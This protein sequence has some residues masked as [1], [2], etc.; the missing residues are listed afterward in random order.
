MAGKYKTKQQEAII[1]C[2][3]MQKDEYVTVNQIEK[4]LKEKECEVGLTTIYRH[5]EKLIED[6]VV[7]RLTVEGQSGACYKFI[8]ADDNESGFYI[9]CEKCGEVAQ[10]KCHH[11]DELYEHVEDDHDFVINTKKT[12]FYGRCGKCC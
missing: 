5:L 9:K 11:L 3:K 2:L 4:Y 10:V 1:N 8:E 12:V 7:A 6:G